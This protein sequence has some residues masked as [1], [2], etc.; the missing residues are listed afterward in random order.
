MKTIPMLLTVLTFA[1]SMFAPAAL[2]AGSQEEE[3][4]NVLLI[5]VDDLN[6]H[7]GCYGDPVVQTPNIDSLAERGVLFSRAYC[8]Y[9]VCNGSRTS[10]L[11]GMYPETTGVWTNRTN[12]RSKIPD[13]V[14]MPKYFDLHGYFTGGV[15]K[16]AHGRFP[17]SLQWD[18]FTNITQAYRREDRGRAWKKHNGLR[19]PFPWRSTEDVRPAI[20]PD[21]AIARRAVELLENHHE[22]P[23][24]IAV[25]FHRP[26]IPH[27]APQ[28]YFD[29]YKPS[30]MHLPAQSPADDNNIPE[31]A[32]VRFY[33]GLSKKQ[34]KSI[35][36]HYAAV[37]SFMDAQV[38][39]VLDAMDRLDLWEETVVVFWSDHGWSLGA[40]DGMWGK[41]SLSEASVRAPLIIAAPGG[42]S[43]E[44][45]DEVVSGIDLFPTLIDLCG[46]PRPNRLQGRSIVKL[47]RNP[48]A[49]L[50]HH[51]AYTVVLRKGEFGR[52]LRTQRYLYINWTTGDGQL[53]DYRK[54]PHQFY[55]HMDDPAY[56]DVV[57]KMKRMM[58]RMIAMT[59]QAE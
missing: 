19:L 10:M 13:A 12:P 17:E 49:Q 54:D 11:S 3:R 56:A 55:N 34:Q 45:C 48:D 24:F 40:H 50:K 2:G 23:F 14:M 8:N 51:P 57:A 29:M 43:G 33:P 1:L 35:V 20:T 47:L 32:R 30:E 5:C 38:G 44:V 4:L 58:D 7:L 37:T 15:G 28:P 39:L 52:A 59:R 42:A 31:V 36:A 53:Y 9:P 41:V 26:H 27:Q 16:I 25:G 6:T 46:L 22:Q 18:S 21:G